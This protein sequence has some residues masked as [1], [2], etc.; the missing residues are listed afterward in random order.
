MAQL[1][2]LRCKELF[3]ALFAGDFVGSTDEIFALVG[4]DGLAE[5]LSA[6]QRNPSR[7]QRRDQQRFARTRS[8]A[9]I[10]Q[11]A[12][13]FFGES[14]QSAPTTAKVVLRFAALKRGI[15]PLAAQHARACIHRRNAARPHPIVPKHAVA[16]ALKRDVGRAAS[17]CRPRI[18]GHHALVGRI[19]NHHDVRP[20]IIA[21]A[22]TATSHETEEES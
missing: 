15:Q 2:L 21:V 18:F 3:L 10:N 14:A 1:A 9:L 5:K 22:R 17:S 6:Q 8:A 19:G 7:D 16:I 12:K 4:P 11:G 13:L 20:R